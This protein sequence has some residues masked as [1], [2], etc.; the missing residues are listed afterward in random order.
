M[1]YQWMALVLSLSSAWSLNDSLDND[2]FLNQSFTSCSSFPVTLEETN[3]KNEEGE[4]VWMVKRLNKNHLVQ[5][6]TYR[7]I[8]VCTLIEED[9]DDGYPALYLCG[10]ECDEIFCGPIPRT[11]D[12]LKKYE[13]RYLYIHG[14]WG[15][16]PIPKEI[17]QLIHL[18]Y[19][20]LSSNN[21][22]GSIPKQLQYLT[23]LRRLNLSFN[24]LSGSIPKALTTLTSL[25]DIQLKSNQLCGNIPE[26]FK[27]L[28][29]LQRINIESNHFT[30]KQIQKC[31]VLLAHVRNA[32]LTPQIYWG[33]AQDTQNPSSQLHEEWTPWTV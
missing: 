16:G 7:A 12:L 30:Y 10:N 13:V 17:G 27:D 21:L 22:S 6:P 29:N 18:T 14:N 19:L 2:D 9:D 24:K 33:D 1:K 4:G 25:Y 5:N 23:N 3:L 8:N 26:K 32:S 20:D 15:F 28:K 31:R 11:I